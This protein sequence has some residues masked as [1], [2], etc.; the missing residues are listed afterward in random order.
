M[1]AKGGIS[2]LLVTRQKVVLLI[3]FLFSLDFCAILVQSTYFYEIRA[4]YLLAL[5]AY[6]G[7]TSLSLAN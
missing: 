3:E 5:I 1:I 2:D 4:Q 6:V 7:F